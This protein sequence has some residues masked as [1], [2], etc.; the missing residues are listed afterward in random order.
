MEKIDI[1]LDDEHI[2]RVKMEGNL[3]EVPSVTTIMKDVG[4]YP[5]SFNSK[6][7]A[8]I[9]VFPEEG[10][11]TP[12]VRG[13]R[14]HNITEE[15]DK[16]IDVDPVD[17]ELLPYIEAYRKFKSENIVTI[18]EIE[19]IVF[20]EEYFF[21]GA[22]DRVMRINGV[23]TIVDIKTGAKMKTTGVQLAAYRYAWEKMGGQKDMARF[24][25]HLTDSGKYKL[26]P[27]RSA[28]DLPDFFAAIRVYNFKRNK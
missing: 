21:A 22:L 12:A 10:K 5:W 8:E 26:V 3:R 4:Y 16:G 14:I 2:Y 9:I 17:P 7:D 27:Y 28:E 1:T 20:N 24:A 6:K 23:P 25:L 11:M 19:E 18:T 13:T 15:I